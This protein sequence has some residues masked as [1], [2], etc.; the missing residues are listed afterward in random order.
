MSI[1][2]QRVRSNTADIFYWC[3][4]ELHRHNE[5]RRAEDQLHLAP[6]NFSKV[7]KRVTSETLFVLGCGGSICNLTNKHWGEIADAGSIGLNL[8][9]L[10]QF[11]PKIWLFEVPASEYHRD[12][13]ASAYLER[14]DDYASAIKLA[15]SL[16][17]QPF[18][19]LSGSI[20]QENGFYSVRDIALP[21]HDVGLMTSILRLLF[22]PSMTFRASALYG[23]G[24]VTMAIM[25]GI[26]LGYK[27]IVLPG[28]DLNSVEYFWYSDKRHANF[29]SGQTGRIHRTLDKSIRTVSS[30]D[31]IRAIAEKA[32]DRGVSIFAGSSQSELAKYL[33]CYW[34]DL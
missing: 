1:S 18:G 23:R 27:K 24:S 2:I 3:R 13:M 4:G 16:G 8:W 29:H 33:P 5:I 32:K 25:I 22:A 11:V 14:R 34:S 12:Y 6:I 21:D 30:V 9:I 17:S 31:V 19:S 28:V 7:Q 10:H 26:R 15:K 20:S